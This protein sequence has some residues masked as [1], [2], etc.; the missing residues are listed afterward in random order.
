MQTF[1]HFFLALAGVE[2]PYEEALDSVTLSHA[3]LTSHVFI[4]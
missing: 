4:W 3:S 1:F 2:N